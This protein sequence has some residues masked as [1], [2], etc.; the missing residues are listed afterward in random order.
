MRLTIIVEDRLVSV[1]GVGYNLPESIDLSWIPSDVWA[2]QWYD[3][4]GEIE[5]NDGKLNSTINDLGIFQQ[6]VTAFNSYT[7][8]EPAPDTVETIVGTL[9]TRV[10]A[11]ESNEASDDAVD[12]ALLTLVSDLS[13][14]VSAL[15]AAP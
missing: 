13:Q 6:A 5:Y 8:P 4:Y 11:L 7:P 14:R 3:T 2:V 10:A 1:D 9:E 12:S 15:E